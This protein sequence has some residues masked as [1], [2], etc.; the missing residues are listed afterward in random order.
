MRLGLLSLGRIGV[1]HP[2]AYQ[3]ADRRL[4]ALEKARRPLA[5]RAQM[6]SSWSTDCGMPLGSRAEHSGCC[7]PR[8]AWQSAG[9]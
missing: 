2:D 6:V 4:G 3:L 5:G 9:R 8:R 1:F 7:C